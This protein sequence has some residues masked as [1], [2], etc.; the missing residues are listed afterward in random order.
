MH[1]RKEPTFAMQRETTEALINRQPDSRI[2][3]I[4]HYL[5]TQDPTTMP[6]LNAVAATL[7]IS[8]S[9]LRHAI[10]TQ[11]GISFRRHVKSLRMGR[12][13]QLLQDTCL[14]VKEVMIGVGM[15]DHSHFAK[16]Y[17]KEFG[18]SPTETRWKALANN[19]VTVCQARI[20]Q[21]SNDSQQPG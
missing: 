13:R 3:A 19:K 21:P 12:A 6:D 7:N 18:E 8:A 4:L 1:A 16:D 11:T 20:T 2:S 15:S 10:K 5:S 14:T 17:K 9:H